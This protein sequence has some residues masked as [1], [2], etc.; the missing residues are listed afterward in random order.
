LCNCSY[1]ARPDTRDCWQAR[2]V[3]GTLAPG[4]GKVRVDMEALRASV[5]RPA[6]T[7][8]TGN[9][10]PAKPQKQGPLPASVEN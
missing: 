7:R 4:S 1:Y 10:Q 6:A 9:P 5:A 2:A 3:W 8:E